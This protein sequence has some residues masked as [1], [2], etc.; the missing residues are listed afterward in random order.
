MTTIF[1]PAM[2]RRITTWLSLVLMLSVVLPLPEQAVGVSQPLAEANHSTPDAIPF[3]QIGVK[4]DQQSKN[5]TAMAASALPSRGSQPRA[6]LGAM[7]RSA[8]RNGWACR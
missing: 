7:A 1:K 6:S 8:M 4:A 3:D 5:V 2:F